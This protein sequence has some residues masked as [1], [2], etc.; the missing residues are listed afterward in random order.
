MRVIEK[1]VHKYAELS[2]EAKERA[3]N[4]YRDHALDYDW[5]DCTFEDVKQ[6]AALMGIEIDQI[7]FS[8]FWSQG[9]GACFTGT[10]AY[11][12]GSLKAI[13]EYAPLDET[14]H[15]I[16][17]DLAREQRRNFYQLQA[18][19]THTGRYNHEFSTTIAVGHA[20][21]SYRDIGGAEDRITELL[22]DFMRWIYRQL[23]AEYDYLTSDEAVEE[24]ITANEYE[25]D[26]NGNAC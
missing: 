11:R 12:K 15:R 17:A 25:F 19:V 9:D 5:W 6:V 14:L 21:D 7:Y 10:Y 26:A 24:G 23:E 8:G 13:R 22:R 3:R 20:E 18:S 2:D 1:T 16:A 4:W